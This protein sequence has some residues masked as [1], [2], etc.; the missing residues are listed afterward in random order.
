MP[1]PIVHPSLLRQKIIHVD[2]DAYYASI[3]V[4][5]NPELKGLPLIVG[6]S[7][8]SRGVVCTASYEARAFGVRSAMS[9]A[10]AARLCPKGVFVRPRFE[11]YQEMAH[12]IRGIFRRYTDR[13]EPLSLDEAYLDV[14]NNSH[15]LYA[16]EI[17]K[18]IR[19][20]ILKDTGLTASAGVAP[21]KMLAKIASEINKPN[22]LAVI[23]PEQVSTFA[24]SLPLRKIHGIGPVSAERLAKHG[25][26]KCADVTARPREEVLELLG[27]NYGEWLYL[28]AHGIDDREV[29][30]DWVRKSF[31]EETTFA[32]D[33]QDEGQIRSEL[34]R[35][36]K[37]LAVT[38]S[39]SETKGRTIHIKVR[40][41]DFTTV[42]RAL[43]LAAAT[44]DP[45]V[46]STVALQL[47]DRTEA[48]RCGVRLLGVSMSKLGEDAEPA[49]RAENPRQRSL[50]GD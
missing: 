41:P 7:P 15:R 26:E 25:F 36:A 29:E 12:V 28:R 31:G 1:D 5:D 16:V 6:G 44:F 34:S 11:R 19:A 17:A 9:C 22:G 33:L 13:V 32:K 46:L 39:S 47:L 50:F 27:E 21:N 10:K 45:E 2:M 38:L 35:L 23:L 42:T 14:T 8:E 24:R 30:T 48:V 37:S 20:E 4:L 49:R 3:E 18:R 40:Y 43:T